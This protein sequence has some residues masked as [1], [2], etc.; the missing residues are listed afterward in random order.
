MAQWLFSFMKFEFVLAKME[1]CG[2]RPD[3]TL[4]HASS[5]ANDTEYLPRRFPLSQPGS[6]PLV[7]KTTEAAGEAMNLIRAAAVSAVL[8]VVTTPAANKVKF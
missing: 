7:F 5:L 2:Y 6:K 3:F 1:V 4:D 8:L